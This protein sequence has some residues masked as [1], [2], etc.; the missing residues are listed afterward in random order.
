[1]EPLSVLLVDDEPSMT[2]MMRV[3]LSNKAPHFSLSAANSGQECLE[4]LSTNKV[5][6]IISDYQMPEMDGMDLLKNIRTQ[7]NEVPFI[8]F[9]G[10][11]NEEVAREA[12]KEGANDYFTKSVGFAHFTRIINSVEQAVKQRLSSE[13]HAKAE[14]EWE[15]TFNA[16][17]DIV[18][19]QNTD[20]VILRANKA[21]CRTFGKE[22]KNIVGRKCYELFHGSSGPV[23]SCPG[24]TLLKK[25]ATGHPD[26]LLQDGHAEVLSHEIPVRDRIYEV[27][28]YPMWEVGGVFNSFVHVAKDITERRH[29]IENIQKTNEML[30]TVLMS[31]Q[32]GMMVVGKDRRI[33]QINCAALNMMGFESE[34]EI[35]G[36]V[37]H[38]T[39]CPAQSGSCPV[40]DLGLIVDMSE[41]IILRRDGQKVPVM[42]SVSI[43]NVG[44][45]DVL[46]ETF[47]MSRQQPSIN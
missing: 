42:K 17:D 10:Q 47:V 38:E 40:L 5:D 36:R 2:D 16:I 27:S 15:E 37:C 9:T 13:A 29:A 32:F 35:V 26:G 41:K 24:A 46:L 4:Y 25:I 19:I 30:S 18:T 1:M 23:D 12:F 31:A 20:F 34:D 43:I 22:C 6:C 28:I 3:V 33:R 7:G 21:A 39:I 11:G 14:K 44:G 8:F 45:E